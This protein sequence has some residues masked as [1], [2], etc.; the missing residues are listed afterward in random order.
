MLRYKIIVT[1]KVQGVNYRKF[2]L[3]LAEQMGVKGFVRNQDDGAVYCEAEGGEKVL[4][5][6]MDQLAIG[7]AMAL[8]KALDVTMDMPVG[9]T[10]FEILR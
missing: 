6:F 2:T 3:G 5:M 7:P 1:G 4:Q 10:Q 9:F 8:V